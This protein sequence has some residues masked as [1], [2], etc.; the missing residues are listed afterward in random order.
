M[1]DDLVKSLRDI[2]IQY[3]INKTTK[4]II[5]KTIFD[6]WLEKDNINNNLVMDLFWLNKESS[7]YIISIDV[8]EE[9]C[10]DSRI[11]ITDKEI[12]KFLNRTFTILEVDPDRENIPH[13]ESVLKVYREFRENDINAVILTEDS[14]LYPEDVKTISCEQL[15]QILIFIHGMFPGL[16]KLLKTWLKFYNVK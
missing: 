5:D 4:Y 2:I 7:R 9:L 14:K 8:L 16:N 10:K 6:G 12:I 3:N 13:N 1:T 11:P 15:I